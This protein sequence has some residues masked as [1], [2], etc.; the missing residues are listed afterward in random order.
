MPMIILML[1]RVSRARQLDDLIVATSTDRSDDPLAEEVARHGFKF[2]R[3][4]L[5]DVLGR[6][7]GATRHI[8]ADIVARLTG[9][10]PL[11]DPDLIDRAISTLVGGNFDYVS[12]VDP[13][14]YPNGLDVEAMTA[15]AVSKAHEEAHILTDREHVTPYIRRNKDVF[16]QST[17]RARVDLSALR[18]TVDHPDD[19]EFVRS[20]TKFLP[21]GSATVADRYDFLRVLDLNGSAIPPN[22]HARNE[23]YI[24]V[25][26][27]AIEAKT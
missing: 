18:W 9:D 4:D 22:N 13:P 21:P 19:L 27:D 24:E 8:S 5:L 14:T 3:G 26:A 12:N 23:N 10:C 1:R 7:E 2:F 16:R 25:S 17:L 20:L 15:A 11:V 6:F